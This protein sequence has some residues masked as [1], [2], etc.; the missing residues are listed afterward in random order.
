MVLSDFC[1][2]IDMCVVN[3]WLVFREAHDNTIKQATL[4]AEGPFKVNKKSVPKEE[5]L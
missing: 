4:K 5:D 1:H 3:L 2:L